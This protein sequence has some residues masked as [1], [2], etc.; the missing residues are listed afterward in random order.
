MIDADGNLK[1]QLLSSSHD[2]NKYSVPQNARFNE[3]SL[4]SRRGLLT[5]T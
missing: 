4:K 3:L 2:F 1:K 5:Q